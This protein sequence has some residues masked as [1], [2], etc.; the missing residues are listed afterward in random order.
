MRVP[1]TA[2]LI[3]LGL[4]ASGPVQAQ[5]WSTD[6]FK[7]TNKYVRGDSLDGC[8]TNSPVWETSDAYSNVIIT[9]IAYTTNSTN[10]AVTARTNIYACGGTSI[11]ATVKGW[12][13][14]LS[15]VDQ[16]N[17]QSVQFGGYGIVQSATFPGITNPA[18]YRAFTNPGGAVTFTTDFAITR[19]A[20]AS[21][22]GK[23]TNWDSFGFSFLDGT[24][25]TN[26]ARIQFVPTLSLIHI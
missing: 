10:G 15:T 2:V 11:L 8:P 12:T 19:T 7:K 6:Y 13:F 18:L 4:V 22:V 16:T 14:G 26:L 20:N 17:N 9:N 24:G 23:Y 21:Y 5:T 3:A 1:L 25:L